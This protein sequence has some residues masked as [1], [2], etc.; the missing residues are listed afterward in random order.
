[1][2][3]AV[4]AILIAAMAACLV[5]TVSAA[6]TG[7]DSTAAANVAAERLAQLN[8]ELSVATQ[9]TTCTNNDILFTVP[10]R[11][12]DNV[13]DTIEYTWNGTAGA[14]VYRSFNG[15]T[16]AIFIPSAQ[17][18]A[19]TSVLRPP[20]VAVES[21]E[22]VLASCDSPVGATYTWD[23]LDD[24]N[25]DAEYVRPTLPSNA[26]SWK[27]TRVRVYIQQ[28]DNNTQ[29]WALRITGASS[30]L[31]PSTPVYASVT[32]AANSV[33]TTPGWVE[34]AIGPVAG[35]APTQWSKNGTG[36]PNNAYYTSTSNAGGA[37]ST[38]TNTQDL[39]FYLI[40]T[41]TTMVEP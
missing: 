25:W 5:A 41:Y 26:V 4:T 16:P 28:R 14:P 11:T 19:A 27:V 34:Y 3:M 7:N 9:I 20:A 38:L 29:T 40:G 2:A 37:W 31:K 22:Q 13:A 39:R 33:S 15:S 10:D 36:H 6:D 17:S 24:Q 30:T 8:A 18:L 12:G 1:M 23:N 35:L 21:A 32:P